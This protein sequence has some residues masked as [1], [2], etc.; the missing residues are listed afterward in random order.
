LDV[1][2][3]TINIAPLLKDSIK[4]KTHET[5]D[6]NWRINRKNFVKKNTQRICEPGAINFSAGWF[7]LAHE[8]SLGYYLFKLNEFDIKLVRKISFTSVIKHP[9]ETSFGTV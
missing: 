3:A 7:G 2:Q 5:K 6:P 1:E 9:N 8:V 4:K